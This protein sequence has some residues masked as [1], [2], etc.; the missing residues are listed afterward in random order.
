MSS[1]LT[2]ESDTIIAVATR[3][4]AIVSNWADFIVRSSLRKARVLRL[5]A[6]FDPRGI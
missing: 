4:A 1:A 6:R 2:G 3:T 5:I